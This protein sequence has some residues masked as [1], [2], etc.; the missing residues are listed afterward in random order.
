MKAGRLTGRIRLTGATSYEPLSDFLLENRGGVDKNRRIVS[1]SEAEEAIG[2]LAVSISAGQKL[3]REVCR[4]QLLTYRS[5][6]STA[7][8]NRERTPDS[9]WVFFPAMPFDR[10]Q[11]TSVSRQYRA[12]APAGMPLRR[13]RHRGFR[14]SRLPPTS[15]LSQGHGQCKSFVPAVSKLLDEEARVHVSPAPS[16]ILAL[17]ARA[18][19]HPV[20]TRAG[21]RASS[22]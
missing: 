10:S 14:Q 9:Y 22:A 5:I 15:F 20:A 13:R 4:L 12:F 16:G 17:R 18:P 1:H 21:S 8:Q 7:S 11:N 3:Q 19:A 2:R 6:L